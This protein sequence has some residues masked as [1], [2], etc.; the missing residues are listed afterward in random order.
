MIPTRVLPL[1]VAPLPGESLD[2]WLEALARRNGLALRVMLSVL[3][4]PRIFTTRL[5]VTSL[6]PHVLRQ[7]EHVTGLAPGRL[8]AAVLDTGF[9]LGPQRQPRCR[10][11]PQCLTERDG[12]WLLRWWLPWVFACTTHQALLHDLC[13]RCHTAPRRTLPSRTHLHPPGTCL[14]TGSNRAVCGT[15]LRATPP[16]PL[17]PGDPLLSAQRWTDDLLA[18]PETTNANTVFR[19]LNTCTSWLLHTLGATDLQDMGKMARDA[20]DRRPPSSRNTRL[21]P[22]SAAVR[23]VLAH[24]ARPILAGPEAEAIDIIRRFRRR[25]DTTKSPTPPGMTFQHWGQLSARAHRRFL[26]AADPEMRPMERLRLRSTTSRASYPSTDSAQS[27][28]TRLQ[29]LP[30]L[31]WPS[32]TVRLIPHEGTEENFF[33]A[34][35]SALLLL[36]GEPERTPRETT[37]RL[38][39]YLPDT[40]GHVLRRSIRKH[41]HVLTALSRLADHLDN[42]GSPIDYQRRRALI[43]AKPISFDAWKQLCFDTGTQPGESPQSTSPTPRFVQA[44]RHLHQLLTGSDLADPAHPLAWQSPGD[45]SRYLAFLPTLNL[46]QHAALRDHAHNLLGELGIHEPLTWEPPET[47][48]AGLSLPGQPLTDID[49]TALER[50][51]FTQ[52]R[53]P[54]EAA[55]ELGTTL[56]NVRFALERISPKPREWTSRHTPLEAW[57][58]RQRARVVLTPEFLDHEY[59]Q[60]EKT[61]TQIAQEIDLPRHI[62]AEQAR[63]VGLTIFYSRRPH[64]IQEDWLREQYLTRKH[65]THHIAQQIGT[66]DETIRR[67]LQQLGIPLRPQGVHSRTVMT[68]NLDD[69]VPRN[70]RAAVEGTLHGWLRLHR[71]QIAMA[72]PNLTSAGTYLGADQSALTTQFQRLETNIG[73]TLFHRSSHTT[74]QH[75]TR[76]GKSLLRQLRTPP[77]Q[78]LM[79]DAL[80][81]DQNLP[82]PDTATITAATTTARHRTNPGPLKPFDDI[83]VERIRITRTTITLLQELLTRPREEF[84]GFQIHART[85]L[86][87]GTIYPRLKQLAQTGWLTARTEDEQ[88]WWERA[89]AGCGPGR[90][91]TYYTL[92]P[93]GT[94]AA[95]HEVQRYTLKKMTEQP[96]KT[97]DKMPG[98]SG[99][100]PGRSKT[101]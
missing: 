38:H 56:T 91:R 84:F 51:I 69:S 41:P 29:H 47:L 75:P 16:R 17:H 12:R 73:F 59:T 55:R 87:L 101:D 89:P 99:K 63:A 65:S 44:Q 1:R 24:N 36:P 97:A 96:D 40:M 45:R 23:G 35:A 37:D 93:E 33:R 82:F 13:P 31:L 53:T 74:P 32:W 18:H 77:I 46:D 26:R 39:P 90:R 61:L 83:A 4:L 95:T 25:R 15:D 57:R 85:G 98:H 70:I 43:P 7:L 3:R 11:C 34:M 94:R 5:L 92:T 52:K 48:A 80:T 58:L 67:R 6:E 42:Q 86:A 9:P 2:S 14:H 72:F 78:K 10:F 49:L 28:T 30:Q 68:A 8:N 79:T 88:S 19:D 54:T 100:D 76:Q 22:L 60:Q 50:I 66:E 62:V 71:F 20:W 64:P 81:P 21:Q 27:T